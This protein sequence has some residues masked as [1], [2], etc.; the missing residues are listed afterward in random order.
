MKYQIIPVTPL[1]QNCSLIICE[2]SNRAALVDPGGEI[3]RLLTIIADA[4]VTLEKILITHAHVDHAGAAAAIAEKLEIPIEGPEPSDQYWIDA[5]PEQAER[6]GLANVQSFTPQR[7]LHQGDQVQVG[8]TTLD[9][10]HCPGHTPGHVVFYVPEDQVALVGDV[11]FQGSIGRSDLPGG[12]HA[13]L[14]NAIR[15]RLWPL[16]NDVRFIPGHG[17]TS[18]FGEERQNNPFVGDGR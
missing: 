8:N 2:E 3:D 12:D 1:Q 15:E 4:G 16:G 11:I 6:F 17:P 14:V 9:V 18:T 10:L 13:T 7:W 5:L